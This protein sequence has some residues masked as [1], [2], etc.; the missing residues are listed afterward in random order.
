[1]SLVRFVQAQIAGLSVLYIGLSALP[2]TAAEPFCTVQETCAQ[3]NDNC[4][5]AEGR[6]TIDV[7]PSGKA[8]VVLNDAPPLESAILDMGGKI[9]LI[10]HD[11]PAEHQLRIE[12]DGQFN[13]L[14]STPDTEAPNGKDQVLY[15]GQCVEG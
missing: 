15:R 8:S 4:H 13:Y 14:I 10:F 12:G 2:A 3:T 6:L 7:L 11:G 1:M 9:I 5:P